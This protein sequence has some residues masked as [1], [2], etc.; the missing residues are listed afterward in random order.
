MESL[1]REGACSQQQWDQAVATEASLRAALEKSQADA[2]SASTAPSV[3]ATAQSTTEQLAAQVRQAEVELAQAEQD[4]AN[5]KIIAPVDGRITKRSVELGNYVQAGQQLG[6]LVGTDLWV[7]ANFKETQLKRMRPGQAAEIRIDAYPGVTL[8]GRVD[9]LQA[10]TGAHFSL[11]PAENAT[12]NFVKVVQRVPVKIVLEAQPES[13][14]HL[15]PG[16]S[17]EP[18]VFTEGTVL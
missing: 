18:T 9:S 12:G 11:F 17:V 6:S 14:I 13:S 5:T 16:M 15:G 7:V 8:R 2:R 3:I 10:G 1:F 4:L